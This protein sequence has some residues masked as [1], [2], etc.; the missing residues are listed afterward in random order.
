MQGV[1]AGYGYRPALA[2]GWF[3]VL[4]L[5]G[6]LVFSV[7]EPHRSEPGRGPA[8]NATVCTLDLWPPIIDFGQEKAF[9]SASGQQWFAY[10]LIASGWVLATTLVEGLTRVPR[11]S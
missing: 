2:G 11:R 7:Y 3:V 9:A 5:L 4:A 6:T 8:I 1:V 10:V